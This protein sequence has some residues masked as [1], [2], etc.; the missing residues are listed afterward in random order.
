MA[1]RNALASRGTPPNPSTYLDGL[2][3]ALFQQYSPTM[4][5]E[6]LRTVADLARKRAERRCS[7]THDDGMMRLGAARALTQ[8]AEDLEVCAVALERPSGSGRTWSDQRSMPD[9]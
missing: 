7:G 1:G 5:S 9:K 3:C 4:D 6:T 8:L 2:A